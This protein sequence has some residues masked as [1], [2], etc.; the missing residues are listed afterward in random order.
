MQRWTTS[1][2]FDWTPIVTFTRRQLALLDWIEAE[3]DPVAFYDHAGTIGVAILSRDIRLTVNQRGMT[4]E[5]GAV[6]DEGVSVLE[7]AVG[8]ALAVLEP[9]DVMMTSGS[10]AW[11]KALEG[12]TYNE[13]RA[14]LARVMSGLGTNN[15]APL[16]IDVSALMDVR[17]PDYSGQVEWGVVSA[18]E[19]VERLSQ[20]PMGRIATNRPEASSTALDPVDLPEASLF[21]DTTFWPLAGDKI[22]DAAG[23]MSAVNG[24]NKVSGQL[25]DALYSQV[26]RSLGG[27]AK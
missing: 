15:G 26:S 7:Q 1:Y 24:L 10:V 3:L 19:L 20:P 22:T 9:R 13:A 16:A 14:G 5:D 12:A 2:R 18:E 25:A 17:S 27:Q 6:L 23:I 11:S 8:G 21:I 4:L